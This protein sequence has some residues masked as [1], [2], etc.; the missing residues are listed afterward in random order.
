VLD[1][2]LLVRIISSHAHADKQ[3]RLEEETDPRAGRRR[4]G[5]YALA[6]I[7]LVERLLVF[8]QNGGVS[9]Y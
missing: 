4:A 2:V 9:G 5:E 7:Q 6:S 8:G 3:E 1:R